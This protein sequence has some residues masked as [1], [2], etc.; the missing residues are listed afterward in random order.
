MRNW[1]GFLLGQEKILALMKGP[2]SLIPEIDLEVRKQASMFLSFFLSPCVYSS[3]SLTLV[4]LKRREER[5][6]K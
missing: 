4:P 6:K 1:P 3:F 5:T 2:S